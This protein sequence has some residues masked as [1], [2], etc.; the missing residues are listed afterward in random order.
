MGGSQTVPR[1]ATEDPRS[2]VDQSTDVGNSSMSAGAVSK[3]SY[4]TDTPSLTR[5]SKYKVVL[6][7]VPLHGVRCCHAACRTARRQGQPCR[8]PS[9]RQP[10][11]SRCAA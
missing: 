9:S 5:L 8:V 4:S 2:A 3:G 7:V 11:G 1:R 10:C 6:V